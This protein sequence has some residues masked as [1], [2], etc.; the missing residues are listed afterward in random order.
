MTKYFCLLLICLL[1][2]TTWSNAQL[3]KEPILDEKTALAQDQT[4]M[5]YAE[6]I[7]IPE[8]KAHLE[9]LAGDLHKGRGNGQEGQKIAA[10]YLADY[11]KKIG[12]PPIVGDSTYFQS[13]KLAI[14]KGIDASINIGNTS[15]EF[16]KD[17]YCFSRSSSEMSHFSKQTLFL[18]YGIDDPKYSDYNGVNVNGK[19]LLILNGEPMRQDATFWLSGSTEP[20]MWTT[21]WRKKIETARKKGA[22][23]LLIITPDAAQKAKEMKGYI[24]GAESMQLEADIKGDN[25]S[26]KTLNT[27]YISTEIANKLLK[28]K[29]IDQLK[30]NID[31]SGTSKRLKIKNPIRL[32]IDKKISPITVENVLGYIEGSDPVLKNELI[33][34]TAHYD[35]LGFEHGETYYGADDDGSGTVALLEMAQAFAQAKAQGKGPKRSVLVM[36][37]AGEEK[38]LLGS[39]YY[40]D[41]APYFPLKNTVANLN[42][43]MIGRIDDNHQNGNYLYIIGADKLSSELH[44]I[45]ENANQLYTKLELD[46]RFNDENDPNRF[47]YRSDHYNFAK[48]KIP[49][50]FYFN[51]VHADYHKPTDTVEKI[52]FEALHQRT[53]LIFYT[54]WDL[55]NRPKRITVDSD[56][57]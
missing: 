49:V 3:A 32:K 21:D 24:M 44:K 23:A 1:G 50:I 4:A 12:L 45:N 46:Y 14:T 38:G 11:F 9:I 43:D 52:N 31:K 30:Q 57:K 15:Y 8:L 7:D 28:N 34:L 33:I 20:S 25:P 10:Q 29:S 42:T 27:F 35:H 39:R 36:P 5:K 19:V 51:G 6:L 17:F 26:E 54:A 56:K 48:N 16:M 13:V 40:T 55:A 41:I 37:V 2:T 18:G 22:A 53:Q 47:Y